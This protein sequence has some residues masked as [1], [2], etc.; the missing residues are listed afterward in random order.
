MCGKTFAYA[1]A[2]L[3][4]STKLGDYLLLNYISFS[5]VCSILLIA[6]MLP[7][8]PKKELEL[9][10]EKKLQEGYDLLSK[11]RTAV[12]SAPQILPADDSVRD[13]FRTVWLNFKDF[14]GDRFVLK[15]SIWW[16]LASCGM[17]QVWNYAQ[18]LWAIMQTE[19]SGNIQNGVT[20][21]VATLLGS[22]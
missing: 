8:L 15:W 9:V 5:S 11:E 6:F 14:L 22:T 12:E 4:I 21:C 20:E 19:N 7:S 10:I 16:S 1:M 2:Q 17:F 3:L 13:Y 18:T